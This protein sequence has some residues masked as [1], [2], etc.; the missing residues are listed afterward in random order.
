[1]VIA[2]KSISAENE[3]TDWKKIKLE[4]YVDVSITGTMTGTTITLQRK[5]RES[6]SESD[7]DTFTAGEQTYFYV[8]STAWYRIGCK[9][10]DYSNTAKVELAAYD[11]RTL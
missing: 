11:N 2:T 9:T 8:P 7:V 5:L 1:M 4:T 6:D 3:F 10:G